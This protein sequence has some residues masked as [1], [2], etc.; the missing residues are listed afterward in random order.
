[1]FETMA[2]ELMAKVD[3]APDYRKLVIELA[4]EALE[5]NVI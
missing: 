4:E 5:R 2:A 1:M 3:A